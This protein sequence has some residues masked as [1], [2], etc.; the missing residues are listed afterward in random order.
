M[1]P[2]HEPRVTKIFLKKVLDK[3]CPGE[4]TGKLNRFTEPVK[5]PI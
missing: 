1:L 3:A 5:L 2:Y 4:Y